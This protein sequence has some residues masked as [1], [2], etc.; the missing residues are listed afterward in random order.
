MRMGLG[1]SRCS[2]RGV[3]TLGMLFAAPGV[4]IGH[5]SWLVASKN[6][7]KA[8]ETVR[9]AFVTAEVFPISEH[10]AKPERV[11]EWVVIHGDERRTVRDYR[12]ENQELAARIHLPKPGTHV[13]ALALHPRYIELEPDQFNEYLEDEKAEAVLGARRARNEQDQPGRELYTKMAKTFIAVDDTSDDTSYRRPVGHAL[14]IIPLSNPCRWTVGD[15]AVVRVLL[16]GEP[17]ASLR[18]SSGNEGLPP[19][20]YVSHVTTDSVGVVRVKLTRPGLWFLRTHTIRPTKGRGSTNSAK[21]PSTASSRTA[22]RGTSAGSG[23]QSTTADWESFWASVTFRVAGDG[24]QRNI[25]SPP[26]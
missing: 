26:P 11:A 2:T 25:D 10:A 15:E 21:Q 17:A 4:A 24:K 6:S 5:D 20:T 1:S 12:I 23:D 22:Q 18:V 8:N 9:L 13:I 16:D 14:E 7:V 3:P 19:H